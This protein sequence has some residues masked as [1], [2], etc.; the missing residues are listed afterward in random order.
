MPPGP[1]NHS[2]RVA[3]RRIGGLVLVLAAAGLWGSCAGRRIEAGVY[4]S[5]KGYRVTLP[6]AGWA[7][8]E[9]SAADLELRRPDAG[10]GILVHATCG[11]RAASRSLS[12]LGRHLLIGL[13]DRAVR[14]RGE[15]SVAGRPAAHAVLDARARPEGTLV[16]IETY[17]VKGERCVYDL[18]Y[19]AVPAAF[20][21]WRADFRRLAES[22]AVEDRP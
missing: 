19:V 16:T 8:V 20:P 5:P 14:E 17:V 12:V 13:R 2:G 9:G 22:L 4:Y 15:V 1:G 7:V 11:G 10:A 18:A 6:E 3:G 21:R